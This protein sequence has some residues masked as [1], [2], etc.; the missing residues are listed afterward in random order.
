MTQAIG[1]STAAAGPF[2]V[3]MLH[4]AAG[5]W[6]LPLLFLIALCLPMAMLGLRAGRPLRVRADHA[7][8]VAVGH[9][10]WVTVLQRRER[11]T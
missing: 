4:S 2:A 6:A 7:A 10:S 11:F 9:N 5:G 1:Y 8:P 3:G